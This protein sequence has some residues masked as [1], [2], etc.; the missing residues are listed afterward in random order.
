MNLALWQQGGKEFTWNGHRLFV[1]AEGQGR[2]LL[3]IHGFPTSSYDWHELWPMLLPH[4]QLHSIDML[5]FGLSDKPKNYAYTLFASADQWQ[6]Y[7][8]SYTHLTLPTSP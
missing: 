1:R 8:V 5:G 3:L 6:E 7:A 2:A 4:Y